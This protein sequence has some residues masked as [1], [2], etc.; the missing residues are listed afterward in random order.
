MIILPAIDI[1]DGKP[2]RLYQG[3]YNKVEVVAK[4]ILTTAK[5]FEELGAQYVHLVDLDGAKAKKL[6]NAEVIIKVAKELNIPVECG[7]G[8]RSMESISYLLDNGVARVILG[9]SAIEDEDLLIKAIE[10]YKDKIAVGIDCKDGYACG[11]GWLETSK[12]HY[13]DFAKH[14][15]KLGVTNIIVTD[16]SKDGTL[17]GPNVEMLETLSKEVNVDITASGGIANINDIEQLKNLNLYGAITGKAI[18]SKSL[19]LKEALELV[20]ED[21]I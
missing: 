20:N 10:K 13:V 11:N 21:N 17:A 15:E 1:I 6:V 2:V 5:E 19:D 16:I 12:L 8:I 3:D 14:L 9:T 18:Y 7:G 4:D